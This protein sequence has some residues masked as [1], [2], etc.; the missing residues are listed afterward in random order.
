[1]FRTWATDRPNRRRILLC[2][3][4]IF[5]VASFSLVFYSIATKSFPHNRADDFFV[6]IDLK[7]QSP[8]SLCFPPYAWIFNRCRPRV[9]P[10]ETA[11][12]I[13][14][15]LFFETALFAVICYRVIKPSGALPRSAI[16]D[17]LFRD[18]MGYYIVIFV[19]LASAIAFTHIGSSTQQIVASQYY[20]AIRSLMCSRLLLRMRGRFS[21]RSRVLDG[22]SRTDIFGGIPTRDI[23]TNISTI[24]EFAHQH[25]EHVDPKI[26]E[27][28]VWID[29]ESVWTDESEGQGVSMSVLDEDGSPLADPSAPLP[30]NV[31]SSS[32]AEHEESG[33]KNVERPSSLWESR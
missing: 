14:V 4:M 1:M 16:V 22:A 32:P 7:T 31:G 12:T 13:A 21:Q 30:R 2:L 18:G 29:N 17:Q 19:T 15:P 33:P 20:V 25:P 10:P 26:P 28:D 3:F 27:F 6:I 23:L 8:D 24:I 9:V 5:F 11:L